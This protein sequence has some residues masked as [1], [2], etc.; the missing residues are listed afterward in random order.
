[1]SNFLSSYIKRHHTLSLFSIYKNHA[2]VG[3]RNEMV[4]LLA[5]SLIKL[6]ASTPSSAK[7][8]E[9]GLFFFYLVFGCFYFFGSN[10]IILPIV[11]F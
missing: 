11:C 10:I 7:G 2:R 4:S 8:I 1:M 3:G 5:Q 9:E 6:N